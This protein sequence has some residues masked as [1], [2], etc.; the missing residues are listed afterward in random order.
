MSEVAYGATAQ[1]EELDGLL[2][3]HVGQQS[4]RDDVWDVNESFKPDPSDINIREKWPAGIYLVR[5]TALTGRLTEKNREKMAIVT[6]TCEAGPLKGQTRDENL[7][8]EG[9]GLGKT[10]FYLSAVGLYE[11][12]TKEFSWKSPADMLDKVCWIAVEH[13]K[14]TSKR[15]NEFINDEIP[16]RDGFLSFKDASGKPRFDIP[17]DNDPFAEPGQVEKAMAPAAAPK[18]TAPAAVAA[19]PIVSASTEPVPNWS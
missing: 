17:A 1:E 9:K 7:M 4:S 3:S 2:N 19:P 6:F 13:V 16:F 8:L 18:A 10:C 11:S 12:S 15:G 5:S 14:A